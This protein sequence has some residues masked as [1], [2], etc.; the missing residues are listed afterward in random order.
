MFDCDCDTCGEELREGG[1]EE[2][3]CEMVFDGFRFD[4]IEGGD[5]TGD[6]GVTGE[7]G[8]EE[9]DDESLNDEIVFT[10]TVF[11]DLGGRGGAADL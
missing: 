11:I 3:E 10:R 7:E 1:A 9:D 6:T 4:I 2:L 5:D 8:S